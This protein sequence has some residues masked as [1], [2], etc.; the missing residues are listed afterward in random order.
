MP[1]NI[2]VMTGNLTDDPELRYTPNGVPVT[3]F[4]LAVTP[5]I[6][7]A[8]GGWRNGETT[9]LPV[10]VWRDMAENVAES[11]SK[12]VRAVVTGRLRTRSWETDDGQ[13][14]SVTELDADEVAPSLRFHVIKGI[15]KPDRTR[16]PVRE[17]PDRQRDTPA[18]DDNDVPF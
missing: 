7:D 1:D 6:K 10:N 3:N 9:F 14:R 5:R 17:A 13:K 16:D 18:L 12:G 8:N 11:L 4:R 2:T 15:E